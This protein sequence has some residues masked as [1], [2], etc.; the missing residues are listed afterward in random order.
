M[1]PDTIR[2]DSLWLQWEPVF[3]PNTKAPIEE[4]VVWGKSCTLWCAPLGACHTVHGLKEGSLGYPT[5]TIGRF[6][7]KGALLQTPKVRFWQPICV[8]Q[9]DSER[10]SESDIVIAWSETRSVGLYE[11]VLNIVIGRSESFLNRSEKWVPN[12]I[13]QTRIRFGAIPTDFIIDP[14]ESHSECCCTNC[15]MLVKMGSVLGSL[16]D[17]DRFRF[18]VTF[19]TYKRIHGQSAAKLWVEIITMFLWETQVQR[20]KLFLSCS[21]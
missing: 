14:L 20:W 8:R 6:R 10:L 15:V 2:S 7:V 17:L 13:R 5:D 1:V 3:R 9:T 11:S 18:N 19:L 4:R 16:E 21:P 12:R